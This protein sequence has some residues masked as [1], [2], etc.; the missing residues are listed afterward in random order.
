MSDKFFENTW[1]APAKLNLF[2]HIIGRRDDGYHLL[3]T[4]FQF[5]DFG[6]RLRFTLRTDGRVQRLNAL[7]GVTPEHDL[8]EERGRVVPDLVETP[9]STHR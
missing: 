7:P 8:V 4:V 5:L 6:D 2:L 1:P 9:E 3:Q